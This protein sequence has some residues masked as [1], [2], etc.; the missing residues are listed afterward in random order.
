M[1]NN[2][3][4]CPVCKKTFECKAEDIQ[5]CQCSKVFLSQEVSLFVQKNYKNCLCYECLL[6]LKQDYKTNS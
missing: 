4:V 3:K 1:K 2:M 6:K 5:N